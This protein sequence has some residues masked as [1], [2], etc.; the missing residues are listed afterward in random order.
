MARITG[1]GGIFFKAKDSKALAAWY[2]DT[3]GLALED[4]GGALIKNDKAGPPHTVWAP[5][6]ADTKYFAP[7]TKD[8]MVNFAVDDLDAF[9]KG[10][11]A[12]GVTILKRDDSDPSGKFAWI[13]DPDGNKIELW[14]PLPG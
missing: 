6:G 7:S 10:L 14:Q 11:E 1:L 8:F 3:L 9:I 13:M 2:R 12:K 5:F 4:W